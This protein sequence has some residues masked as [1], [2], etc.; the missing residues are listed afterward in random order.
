MLTI[1][2]MKRLLF[3]FI[4]FGLYQPIQA[5]TIPTGLDKSEVDLV[6]Q[7]LG[8]NTSNKLLSNPFPLGGY[9]G[10]EVGITFEFINTSDLSLLGN[11]TTPQDNLTYPRITVGKGVYNNVDFFINFIPFNDKDAISEYGGLVKWGVYQ[12]DLLPICVSLIVHSNVINFND[13]FTNQ[14]F[15]VEL[16]SG[17]YV[18]KFSLYVGAGQVQA[19]GTLLSS[20]VDMS[21]PNITLES[22]QTFKNSQ[23]QVHSFI[24]MNMDF[25][26]V[27]L[28][29]QIDRYER[30]V[31]SVKLGLKF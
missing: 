12:A 9:T 14:N 17:I 1:A 25:K 22:D 24:G 5:L 13:Q 23:T 26:N 11:T 8:L 20:L 18:N 3:L 6:V 27:F 2:A 15:G 31:Y 19:S 7:T 4:F 30:P 16:I 28:A 29:A 10:F 21:D